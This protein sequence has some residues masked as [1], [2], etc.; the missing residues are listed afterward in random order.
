MKCNLKKIQQGLQDTLQEFLR[1]RND[2]E[3]VRPI[4]ELNTNLDNFVMVMATFPCK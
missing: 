3:N 2:W 4:K 1:Y